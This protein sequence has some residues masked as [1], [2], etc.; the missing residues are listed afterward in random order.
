MTNAVISPIDQ[1]RRLRVPVLDTEMSYVDVGEGDP[2]VFLHGNPASSYLW[3]NV[4]PY[5]EKQGRCIAPDL[6]GMGDS[7][8]LQE[9]GPV[10]TRP[11]RT[12]FHILVPAAVIRL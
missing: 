6:M 9:A 10:G 3:R 8:K 11:Q 1:H 4:I 2:I 5:L 12:Q 7:Q